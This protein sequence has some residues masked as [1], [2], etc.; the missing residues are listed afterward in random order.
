MTSR[1]R[2]DIANQIATA[3]ITSPHGASSDDIGRAVAASLESRRLLADASG[4]IATTLEEATAL[5]TR[6]WLLVAADALR[7]LLLS[8]DVLPAVHG[9]DLSTPKSGARTVQARYAGPEQHARRDLRA[10]ATARGGTF[11]HTP[12]AHPSW[13]RVSAAFLVGGVLFEVVALVRAPE[14]VVPAELGEASPVGRPAGLGVAECEALR[15]VRRKAARGLLAALR[16]G[17]SGEA[18]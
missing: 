10:L 7:E 16:P 18:C 11:G 14:P 6:E 9:W 13:V 17:R 8:D 5:S 12:H 4:P 3:V 15:A 2:V 1:T